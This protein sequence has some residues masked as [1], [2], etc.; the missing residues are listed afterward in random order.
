[1]SNGSGTLFEKAFFLP[2]RKS[3]SEQCDS[4]RF[5]SDFFVGTKMVGG[6]PKKIL[7]KSVTNCCFER[8]IIKINF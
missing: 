1:M 5:S 7:L 3:E 8:I 2:F 4:N 6:T